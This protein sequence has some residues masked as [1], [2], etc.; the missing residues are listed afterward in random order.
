MSDGAVAESPLPNG[1]PRAPCAYSGSD[2]PRGRAGSDTWFPYHSRTSPGSELDLASGLHGPSSPDRSP[3]KKSPQWLSPKEPNSTAT[4]FDNH[5]RMPST[6]EL[7]YAGR[8]KCF[9]L[10]LTSIS[11]LGNAHDRAAPTTTDPHGTNCFV[12]LNA[13]PQDQSADMGSCA[14][15]RVSKADGVRSAGTGWVYA[16][17]RAPA[18]AA[19]NGT[20]DPATSFTPVGKRTCAKPAELPLAASPMGSIFPQSGGSGDHRSDRGDKSNSGSVQGS[21]NDSPRYNNDGDNSADESSDWPQDAESFEVRSPRSDQ[22]PKKIL[23]LCVENVPRA[24]VACV[25]PL[26][27]SY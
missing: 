11:P 20:Y 21:V 1:H 10:R 19:T 16:K 17:K 2:L 9:P 13:A 25:H 4:F 3:S 24:V 14:V 26:L 23:C 22:P 18:A 27:F 12:E 5:E 7:P 8:A 15:G 6:P